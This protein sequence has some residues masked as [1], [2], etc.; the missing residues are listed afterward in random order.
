M[1]KF[2]GPSITLFDETSVKYNAFDTLWIPCSAKFVA[3]GSTPST[4][5]MIQTYEL[6]DGK[7]KLID[8]VSTFT[9]RR[10]C[11]L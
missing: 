9:L 10:Y 2:N 1:E 4:K 7:V 8:E 5:G 3:L 11:F 6:C